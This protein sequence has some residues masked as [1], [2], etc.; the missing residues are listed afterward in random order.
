MPAPVT[1]WT[2]GDGAGRVGLTV[3]SILVAG[4]EPGQVLGLIDEDSDFWDA[5]PQSWV[6]NVLGSEHRFLAEAFAGTAPAPG[7][8]F[9][10]G[11]W[12][13]SAWGPVLGG[14]A[15][16]LGVRIAE[17][18]RTVGW[19]LLVHGV[20]ESATVGDATAMAHVRGRYRD[21]GEPDERPRG[22]ERRP[23]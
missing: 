19:S 4:G 12:T 6:V 1:V 16:W 22:E 11:T 5:E 3:S 18:P 9:T 23:R 17:P 20:V 10:L 8:P 13:Q 7:G 2:A 21:L 14:N 15:G